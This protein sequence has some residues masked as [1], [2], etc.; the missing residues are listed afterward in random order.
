MSATD[1]SASAGA[2]AAVEDDRIP[3]TLLS[4]FLGAGKTTLLSHLLNNRCG[5]R[6]GLVINDMSDLNI[7]A[8]LI[9]TGQASMERVVD[10]PHGDSGA[11]GEGE[12]GLIELSNGCIC[13][14]L[15]E[16]LLSTLIAMAAPVE[17][18]EASK[19]EG[20]SVS[21]P[22]LGKLLKKRR[23]DY[24]IIESSGISEPLPVAETFTFA[25]PEGRKLSDYCRLDC[26]VTVVDAFN[27]S[28]DYN[29]RT[30]LKEKGLETSAEDERHVVDLLIDQIEFSNLIVLNKMDLFPK[31]DE[32]K[33]KEKEKLVASLRALNPSARIVEATRG[34]VDVSGL[35]MAFYG[36]CGLGGN[37]L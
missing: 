11:H 33:T 37:I 19:A 28:R 10:K 1:A 2:S 27:F 8:E 29:S 24:L 3:V 5:L 26:C 34:N 22:T 32:E 16:D 17:D 21:L 12:K 36:R 18:A 20:E 4:G 7:D 31:D 35:L 23:F 13:C 30:S 15:R 6:I 9:R 25:D 14:T